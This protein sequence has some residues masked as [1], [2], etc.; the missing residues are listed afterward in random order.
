MILGQ[1][2]RMSH[3]QLITNWLMVCTQLFW[4][5]GQDAHH[6]NKKKFHLRQNN[7]NTKSKPYDYNS[8]KDF[9]EEMLRNFCAAAAADA[10][11][12]SIYFLAQ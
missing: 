5:L 3:A 11:R 7:K 10:Y 8:N 2:I 6:I 9:T 12:V 4:S 1:T